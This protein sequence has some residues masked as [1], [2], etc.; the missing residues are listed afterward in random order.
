MNPPT[1]T[2]GEY[3][4]Q[5]QV[6]ASDQFDPDSTANN[7]DPNEDDQDALEVIPNSGD[8]SLTKIVVDNDITPIVGSEIT[9]E[10]TIFNDG[11]NNATGVVVEDQLPS[12]YDFVLFSST[13]GLYN[14]NTGV[15][16]V[17]NVASGGS[18]TLLIDV[19]VNATGIYENVAEITASDVFDMDSTP[20][21]N[22]LAEDDQDNAAVTP[23]QIADVS[24]VKSVDTTTP[25][26]NTEVTFTVQVTNNGPSEATNLVVTD[27][28]P[29]GYTYVSDNSGGAYNVGS[30]LWSIGTLISGASA[31]L[32]VVANVN[33]SGAYTNVAEVTAI[34]Q[35]DSD[36]T[37][38]N[39]ILAE[40]DQDDVVVTPRPIVDISVTKVASTL[41][42]NVGSQID[43]DITVTND[44][45]SDATTV[46]VTDLLGSGYAFVSALPSI[47]TYE[48]LNGSWTVGDMPIGVTQTLNPF[49]K[50]FIKWRVH[51]YG[52]TNGFRRI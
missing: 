36:S 1:G 34:D 45:P 18:E 49:S 5:A 24:L 6:T 22:V 13:A 48:A 28:L 39:N 40:D 10:I 7:D 12:G 9:F 41:T 21:N 30:G 26:V 47:G 42:P 51:Q 16:T 38:N 3:L 27:R 33:A 46:V 31:T 2:A 17:G 19:L 23:M 20:N 14:E 15:W 11:P 43:F 8:L 50:R 32:N 52:R 44:G 4:N 25:D 37:P 35:M 29:S